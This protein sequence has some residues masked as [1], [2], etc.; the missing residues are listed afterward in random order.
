MATTEAAVQ[1]NR[2]QRRAGFAT[3]REAAEFLNLGHVSVYAMIRD[4]QLASVKIRNARRVPW[5]A[6]YQIADSAL[7]GGE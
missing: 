6:L 4:N 2:E 3:I 1:P 5:E 7:Q